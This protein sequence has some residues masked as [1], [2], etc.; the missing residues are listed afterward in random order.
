MWKNNYKTITFYLHLILRL[1][2]I[3]EILS[4][5]QKEA[6]EAIDI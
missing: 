1:V 6:K 2:I 4:V 5:L 3:R